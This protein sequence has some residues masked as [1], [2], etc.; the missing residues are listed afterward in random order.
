MKCQRTQME[1]LRAEGNLPDKAAEHIEQCPQ[2]RQ[3]ANLLRSIM[4]VED[5]RGPSPELDARVLAAA[6]TQLAREPRAAARPILTMTV[7]WAAAAAL[8]ALVFTISLHLSRPGERH[9]SQA[10]PEETQEPATR[11]ITWD[12]ADMDLTV[13]EHELDAALAQFR[14]VAEPRTGGTEQ[15][16]VG[17]P[18]RA[19]SISG[20]DNALF[21]LECDVYFEMQ[22]IVSDG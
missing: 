11:P 4:S 16:P 20:L 22:E 6:R 19:V 7:R 2:C 18:P 12:T 21:E 8:V 10:L 9:L 3:F 5:T 13:I 14:A 15:Y 17:T 1:I